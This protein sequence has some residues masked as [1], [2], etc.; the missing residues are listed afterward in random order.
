MVLSETAIEHVI[1]MRREQF[2]RMNGIEVLG[3]FRDKKVPLGLRQSIDHLTR[4]II[5]P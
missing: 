2:I 4:S 1:R 5:C 3:F